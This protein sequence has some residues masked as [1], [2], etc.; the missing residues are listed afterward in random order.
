MTQPT[1]STQTRTIA[2]E[3]STMRSGSTLLKAL[4]SAAPDISSLPE[5][6]FTKYQSTD[7]LQKIHALCEER[8]I[9]LKRPSWFNDASRYPKLPAV[10]NTRQLI[11][12]RDVHTNVASLRKMVF[13]KL[14]PYLP[15]GPI[16]RWLANY[17]SKSYDSLLSRFPD[18]GPENFWVPYED[19]V[20][21]PIQ[22]TEK[23]FAFL[24]SER[25]EGVDSYPPPKDFEWKWGSDDGGD[26]IKSLKVQ[27]NPI[28][29]SSLDILARVRDIPR[30][31]QTRQKLGYQ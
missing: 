3:L 28:P 22:W 23:I 24:G 14:E 17:W 16:D 15:K 29:Q 6:N 8:I 19:L 5:V 10:P 9:V 31:A 2:I 21:D 7:A 25:T 20:R 26:K 1:P 18:D 13:R 30:V 12:T 27:P 4:M 11:L